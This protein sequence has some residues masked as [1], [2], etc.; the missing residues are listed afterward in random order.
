VREL[1]RLAWPIAVSMVSYAVMTT[2]DTLFVGHLGAYALAGVGLAGVTAFMLLTFC[3]GLLRGVKI[4]ASQ[5]RGA[6]RDGSVPPIVGAG[7]IYAAGMGALAIA[8]G[9]MIADL[10]PRFSGSEAAGAAASEYLAIRVLAAP[11]VLA[12]VALREGS[13][14]LGDTRGP[15]RASIAANLANV[16]LDTLL[17]YGVGWGVRGAALASVAATAVEL[18]VICKVAPRVELA[19][20][21]RGAAYLKRVFEVGAPTGFQFLIE[22]GSF[23]ALSLMLSAL[24]EIEMASHQ[25]ALQVIHFSF[26][27]AVALGEAASVMAGQAVGAGR[28]ELVRPVATR[29]MWIGAAYTGLCTA[30]FALAAT[31]LASAFTGDAE[32]IAKATA[33]LYVAA[34]FQIGDGANVIAR[35]V[36]RGTGDVTFPAVVGVVIAW[37]ITPPATYL[38]GY[39]AGLGALG[40]WIGLCAEILVGAVIY[41]RRLYRGGWLASARRSRESLA[42]EAA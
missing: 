10:L 21:R 3:F 15:M 25:I 11:M 27:P 14:G 7:L 40:G 8:A 31:P 18:A 29:A 9:H 33:L 19:D 5:A 41:W 2:V 12:F 26:L 24:A 38:L 6:G 20:L 35:N 13:Y 28:D 16:G 23:M 30:V 37:V 42:L 32:V 1:L 17:I 39:V 36:L 4:L 34:A 22:V